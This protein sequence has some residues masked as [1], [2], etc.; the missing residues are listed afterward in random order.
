L[1]GRNSTE[2]NID[3]IFPQDNENHWRSAFKGFIENPRQDKACYRLLR[4]RGDYS[5]AIKVFDKDLEVQKPLIGYICRGYLNR[6]E[7]IND[8]RSSISEVI[9]YGKPEQ[10]STIVWTILD[11]NKKST[12]S[13]EMKERV[14]TLW[15]KL[16]SRYATGEINPDKQKILAGLFDWISV[17]DEIDDEMYEWLKVSAAHVR[18]G[19]NGSHF[20]E[21]L[22]KHAVKTPEKVAELILIHSKTG[23]HFSY[24]KEKLQQ[25]VDILYRSGQKERADRI[26]N[27]YLA[28]GHDYL[29]EIYSQNN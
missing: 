1:S 11:F 21:Y 23:N 20:F 2:P 5:K 14:K 8:S 12:L 16:I 27:S 6:E 17:F 4:D 9:K 10:I 29:R 25:I 28:A 3:K 18:Y 13:A 24:K 26:C 22:L 7:D 19:R 15:G